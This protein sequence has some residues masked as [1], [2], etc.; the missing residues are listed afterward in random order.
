MILDGLWRIVEDCGM[1]Q[2]VVEGWG[3]PQ[4]PFSG[5]GVPAKES[6]P[7]SHCSANLRHQMA[8]A[9]HPWPKHDTGGKR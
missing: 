1:L 7:D 5:F 8:A 4:L 6:H 9:L 3:G 2:T